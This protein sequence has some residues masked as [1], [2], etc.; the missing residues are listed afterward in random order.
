MSKTAIQLE[1][2]GKRYRIG[3]R[4]AAGMYSYKSL[5]DTL[6]E[7]VKAPLREVRNRIQQRG[8]PQPD[9][10]RSTI[11]WALRDISFTV[12]HGEVVG[13]VG[14]N[15]AGKSTLLK[16]ISRITEPTEGRVGIRGRVGSLLEIGTGFHPELT[17]RENIALSGAILGMRR[18]EIQRKFDE[19]VE[20]AEIEKFLDTPVKHFSTGMY[21]RLA[22]SVAAHLE[23]EILVIDEVL[24]VGDAEF[25]KKCLGKMGDVA[26]TGRTVLFVS[27]NM[28]LIRQ[29]CTRG[30]LLNKGNLSMD[31]TAADVTLTYL[32]LGLNQEGERIWNTLDEAPG[33]HVARLWAA[34]VLGED[35]NICTAFT[36]RD[37]I[38][39]ELIY[40]VLQ[41]CPLDAYI[42]LFNAMGVRIFMSLDNRNSPW[43]NTAR[44]SGTYRSVCHIPRDLLNPGEFSIQINL[45]QNLDTPIMHL[46]L[47]NVVAF[48]V[49]DSLDEDGVRGNYRRNWPDCA[50]RPRL[51]WNVEQLEWGQGAGN[52]SHG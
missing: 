19:I 47:T 42:Y 43:C 22:F 39:I 49:S 34:R 48:A 30:I 6:A 32:R 5:R 35:G 9:S 52:R 45:S 15:G 17:G 10:Q 4:P 20:F 21:M 18:G 41:P 11:F 1:N 25:Q 36:V 46:N 50:V 12:E 31:G 3:Q 51:E 28:G 27:H 7:G 23:P 2:L 16:I 29:L 24:A 13:I 38:W 44:P 14:R 8:Y 26:K 40:E 33:N 37:D